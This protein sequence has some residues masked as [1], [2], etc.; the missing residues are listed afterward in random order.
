MPTSTTPVCTIAISDVRADA[1]TIRRDTAEVCLRHLT[2]DV[3]PALR[4]A[5]E[6]PARTDYQR[7]EVAASKARLRG[8]ES[9]IADLRRAVA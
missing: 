9:M 7:E 3:L 5:A 2:I 1:V 4:S 6:A 8:L